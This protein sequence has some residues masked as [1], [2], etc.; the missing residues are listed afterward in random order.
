MEMI[1]L[2][3]LVI[4]LLLLAV[5]AAAVL[6]LAFTDTRGGEPG[7][8]K[9]VVHSDGPDGVLV[10]AAHRWEGETPELVSVFENKTGSYYVRDKTVTVAKEIMQPLNDMMD[11]FYAE[12]GLKRVNVV[13]GYRTE[14][15][16]EKLFREE[17]AEKGEKEAEKWVNRPGYSEHHT[18]LA[19]DLSLF[20]AEDG[21]SARFD[22][23]GDYAW[24]R[25]NSWRYGFILRYTAEKQAIT[26]ISPEPWHFRY[27]G[28]DAAGK[29][30]GHGLCLEEYL[31]GLAD[32][33]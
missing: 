7:R 30:Y 14:E 4:Y 2:K 13:S 17:V 26:G 1:R 22:G 28:S 10:N 32:N 20:F 5:A 23:E 3:K 27:V 8:L 29:I 21:S 18:G 31:A 19:V 12:T 24:F 11:A 16:Q 33:G 9:I 15:E 6:T 25:E